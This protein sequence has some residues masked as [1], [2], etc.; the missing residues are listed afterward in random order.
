MISDNKILADFG[1]SRVKIVTNKGIVAYEYGSSELDYFLDNVDTKNKVRFCYSTVNKDD[2]HEIVEKLKDKGLEAVNIA[3]AINKSVDI[4]FSGVTGMGTDRKLSL[5]AV[6]KLSNLPTV[7]VDCGT[8]ITVNL[9]DEENKCLGGVIYPG[10]YTQAKALKEFTSGL[11]L[12]DK[13]PDSKE[14]YG[15]NTDDAI[16]NGIMNSIIGGIVL[17]IKNSPFTA[18]PDVYI[19]GGYGEHLIP[20]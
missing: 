10:F 15:D 6:H 3:D 5:L 7:T 18:V 13:I 12:I 2:S 19:T 8:A 4:D 11:P 9:L 17:T 1:N 20:C 16:R 14:K